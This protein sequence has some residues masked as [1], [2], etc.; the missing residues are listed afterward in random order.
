M[1]AITFQNFGK[2]DVLEIKNNQVQPTKNQISQTP[3]IP[4]NSNCWRSAG[5]RPGGT[6]IRGI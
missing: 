6:R 1:K 5:G 3:K 2:T 4:Y